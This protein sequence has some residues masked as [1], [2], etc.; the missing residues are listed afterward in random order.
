MLV[1]HILS[2]VLK[3]EFSWLHF[4]QYMGLHVCNLMYFHNQIRSIRLSH[5]CHI[6]PWLCVCG[7]CTIIFCH[8]IYICYIYIYISWEHLVFISIIDVQSIFDVKYFP[9]LMCMLCAYAQVHYGLW[10][11]FVCLQITLSHHRY[12][13]AL[14]EGIELLK[15]LRD[16]FCQMCV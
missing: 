6:F 1:R 8:L 7:G 15:C 4:L 16:I 14:Y 13:T 12:Y 3:M 9:L 5:C 10:V 2:R 11:M